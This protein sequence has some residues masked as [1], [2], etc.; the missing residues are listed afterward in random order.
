[1]VALLVL[2]AAIST[3]FG[4]D[5]QSVDKVFYGGFAFAGNA[6]E[7]ARNYPIA[8]LLNAGTGGGDHFFEA[9]S[10]EF[11]RKN[12]TAFSRVSLVFDVARPED[13]QFVL[14][15]A[16]SDEKIL[17]EELGD[18]HKLVIQLGLELLVLDFH[19]MEVV[20]SRPICI[21]LIDARKEAFTDDDIRTRMRSMVEGDGSQL[22][23]ALK[24][25]FA[26]LS[27]RGRNQCTLQIRNVSIGEKALPFLPEAYR[28][29]TAIYSQTVAQQFGSLLT[30]QAGLALLPY[31][32]DG[33][34]S[35]MSLRFA[36]A[37]MLQ[38]TIPHPTF[39]IDVK[40]KGFK[41]VLD[42]ST[43]AESLWL[44]GAFLEVRISEPDF[45]QVYFD[46]PV[47]YG[48]SKVVPA[49]QK[50]VDE[51]P[52]V[53][54]ALKGAFVTSIEQMQSDKNTNDKILNKC[55]L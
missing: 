50:N 13:T 10:R 2:S 30:S 16:L 38:F 5:Q 46:R 49:T 51:F 28:K 26:G 3:A 55:K 15:L 39:A 40:I 21:E 45:N 37:S 6:G 8:N 36:D 20:T 29:A 34:N 27:V 47:K 31:A 41:K 22:F 9:Q 23:E 4:G 35:K 19:A 33:L 7:I 52:V 17:R 42:K 48:V 43:E 14:A 32:K 11:F 53:S 18:F 24:E 25:K 54:E 44:Y 1:M 12:A